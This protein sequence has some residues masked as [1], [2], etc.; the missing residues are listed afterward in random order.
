MGQPWL[1]KKLRM[2]TLSSHAVVSVEYADGGFTT[3]FQGARFTATNPSFAI[4]TGVLNR[5]VVLSPNIEFASFRLRVMNP[6]PPTF[7]RVNISASIQRPD[8]PSVLQN[9]GF[10]IG[11][12][13][14]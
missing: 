10:D 9:T 1:M 13:V 7:T 2:K 4:G 5:A 6:G 14:N 12:G 3:H 11:V 8:C